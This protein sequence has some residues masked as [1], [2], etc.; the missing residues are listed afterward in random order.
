MDIYRREC[1]AEGLDPRR[2]GAGIGYHEALPPVLQKAGDRAAGDPQPDD[3]PRS[4][5]STMRLRRAMH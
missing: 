3:Q 4:P 1:L 2:S 5:I